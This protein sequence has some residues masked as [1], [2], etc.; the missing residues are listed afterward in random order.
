ME[1]EDKP[2]CRY[3]TNLYEQWIDQRLVIAPD[4]R[5]LMTKAENYCKVKAGRWLKLDKD[6][7]MII[8]LK[9]QLA[10]KW[11]SRR[12]TGRQDGNRNKNTGQRAWKDVAPKEGEE[13]TK[14][15][16]V[17]G[18][19][20]T[21]HWCPNHK[22]WTLHKPSECKAKD[23]MQ[24]QD[25]EK[26]W[27][28]KQSR[29]NVTMKVMQ[30]VMEFLSED[31]ND[32]HREFLSEDENDSNRS[33]DSPSDTEDS[34]EWLL[35]PSQYLI[36]LCRPLFL[37]LYEILSQHE[38]VQTLYAFNLFMLI[39]FDNFGTQPRIKRRREYKKDII[40]KWW[41]RKPKGKVKRYKQMLGNQ[42]EKL[43]HSK[44]LTMLMKTVAEDLEHLK[45]TTMMSLE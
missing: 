22:Q 33:E 34:N 15:V 17:K 4:G 21:Y 40:Q 10:Q 32:S 44:P 28:D 12:S 8:T 45:V 9:A 5:E 2:F 37:L 20:K 11:G 42:L 25:K 30:S 1:A 13:Q 36:S 7:E 19:K 6:Q 29:C 43:L 18:K 41:K 35:G 14:E 26:K 38:Y 23:D 24:E 27:G 16:K 39:V 3:I 31:E